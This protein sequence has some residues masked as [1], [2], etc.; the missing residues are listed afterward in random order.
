M[1]SKGEKDNDVGARFIAPTAIPE[2][3][4]LKPLTLSTPLFKNVF[5]LDRQWATLVPRLPHS[6]LLPNDPQLIERILAVAPKR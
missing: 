5:A 4:M 6:K 1:T 3:P 2:T